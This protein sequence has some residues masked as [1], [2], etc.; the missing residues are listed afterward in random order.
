MEEGMKDRIE[1]M[2][3]GWMNGWKEN[4]LTGRTEETNR[5]LFPHSN[6]VSSVAAE[7]APDAHKIKIHG[8]DD[9]AFLKAM[10]FD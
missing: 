9:L 10:K 7:K 1:G 3:D 6:G 2:T 8:K 4:N 5:S